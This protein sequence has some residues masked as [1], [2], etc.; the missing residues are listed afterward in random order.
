VFWC[1]VYNDVIKTEMTTVNDSHSDNEINNKQ[2]RPV[3]LTPR[4]QAGPDNK[5]SSS[6]SKNCPRL[7]SFVLSMSSNFLFWPLENECNDGTGNH[8]EFAII[9][10]SY[11]LTYLVILI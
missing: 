3:M 2:Q 4:G 7:P 9:Y 6:A 8:C 5:I 10:Q 11:L 1:T